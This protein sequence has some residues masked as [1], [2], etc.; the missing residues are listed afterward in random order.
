[1][2]GGFR[3]HSR[4]AQEHN[5]QSRSQ[6]ER[7]N[8]YRR[9][10][11]RQTSTRTNE[12]HGHRR[13]GQ[14]KQDLAREAALAVVRGVRADGAFANIL[15]S[16]ELR[17]RRLN[18]QDSAFTTE[19]ANGTVRAQGVL[20]PVIESAASRSIQDIDEDLIDV[21]RLGTYQMLR[22]NVPPHAAVST[23][24]E[25]VRA[26]RGQGAAGFVNAVLR[27]VSR[28]T[29][30]EWAA[31][32][33]PDADADPIGAL[34]YQTAHPRWIVE[35]FQHALREENREEE[36]ADALAADDE[37]PIVHLVALPGL[38]TADE[39]AAMTG[40][41]VGKISD[42]AVHLTE[43]GNPGRLEVVR[44]GYAR[45]Q[46]EG[47]QVVA[48]A[49]VKAPVE[50]TEQA[51]E[52]WLDLCAGPGGKAALLGAEAAIVGATVVAVEPVP[53][54]AELV[55]KATA[56]LPVEVIEADGTTV[57]AAE[58]GHPEGFD[59]ILV[60][61]PCSGLGSL[62]RRP[63]SRWR[64][65]PS[66]LADLTTLQQDLLRNAA[67]LLKPGGVVAYSTCSPH[68]LE[69]RMVVRTVSAETGLSQIDAPACFDYL[70]EVSSDPAIQLWP[71]RHGTD[72]MF[73][74]LL[75]RTEEN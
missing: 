14:I 33:T 36:L 34:S 1:M 26:E 59:R 23:S 18:K 24:T 3:A 68:V 37:R 7:G 51:A 30:E 65:Q 40:G 42:Y 28:K 11:N 73:V 2:S 12:T 54:R 55:R 35:A 67:A 58:L 64:R 21:L 15:L 71:H 20:D 72:A 74:S 27:N 17:Q 5:D 31:E 9:S 22:T 41:E 45:V 48:R 75:Q 38:V 61:A 69:T 56:D 19:L 39:V 49:L 29:P 63:E 44:D 50:H 47:S 62:R 43:G 6:V 8:S 60:D 57:T 53:H 10:D 46:D 4:R 70:P 52:V 25:L 13:K 66:D 16:Q 32:C